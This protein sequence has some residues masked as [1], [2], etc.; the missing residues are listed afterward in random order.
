MVAEAIKDGADA[1]LAPRLGEECSVIAS[2]WD[3]PVEIRRP[4]RPE[5]T[6]FAFDEGV[7]Q[8]ELAIARRHEGQEGVDRLFERLKRKAAQRFAEHIAN[9]CQW[10]EVKDAM[11]RELRLR[12][13]VTLSDRGSYENWLPVAEHR[14][15]HLGWKQA[16]QA[17]TES[18]PY[19]MA[20]AAREFYE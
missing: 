18:L 19:G 16:M 13:E 2:D 6:L 14:G 8:H 20:D 4:A 10:F 3:K 15:R 1:C 5:P 7:D 11:S 17:C 12:L 9:H